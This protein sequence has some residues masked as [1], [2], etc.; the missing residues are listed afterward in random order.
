MLHGS[1]ADRQ[2][3]LL[4]GARGNLLLQGGEEVGERARAEV[5][6]HSMTNA[7]GARFRLF[8]ADDEHIRNFL[9]LRVADFRGQLF[10]AVVEVSADAMVFESLLD[11]SGVVLHFFADRADFSLRRSEPEGK[12]AGVVFDK[13]A[14]KALDGAE[15]R[16]VNHQGLVAGAIVADILEAEAGRQIEVELHGGELP[17]SANGVDELHVNLRA[18][19]GGFAFHALEGDLHARHGIRESVG[20]AVPVFGLAGVIFGM[21]RIPVRELDLELIEAE[22]FHDGEGEVD[23]GFDFGLDLLRHTEDV[24]V[25]LRE[26]ADAEEAVENATPLVAVDGAEFSE[27]DGQIAIAAE[28]GPVNEDVAGAIHRLQLV[29]GLFDFHNAVHLFPVDI[30]VAGGLP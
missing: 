17:G 4:D 26:T 18:I 25:V 12:R 16:A 28:L 11:M 2:E 7:N 24:G 9:Q 29:I 23:A 3:L 19:E 10:V 13:H 20:S 27:A 14:E 21:L 22:I 8:G 6:F 15:Q 5:A 30:G 1:G